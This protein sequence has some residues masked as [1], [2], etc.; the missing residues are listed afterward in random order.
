MSKFGSKVKSI[1][2]HR[3]SQV[4]P[5]CKQ[6]L[7]DVYVED[8]AWRDP[9]KVYTNHVM[10]LKWC[11]NED[12]KQKPLKNRDELAC[13]NIFAKG[14]PEYH[15][16]YDRA[17]VG[18]EYYWSGGPKIQTMQRYGMAASRDNGMAACGHHPANQNVTDSRRQK[19]KSRKRISQA[20]YRAYR[21]SLAY[22]HHE[23][24]GYHN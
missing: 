5:D 23:R 13:Y 1:D 11:N 3:T 12:C 8:G 6:R 19:R 15:Q 14:E 17:A 7:Y 24:L 18:S 20:G 2:K 10:G 9:E 22:Q 4:C 21:G 16:I